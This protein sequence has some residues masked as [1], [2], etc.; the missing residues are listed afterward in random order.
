MGGLLE[1]FDTP[2][3]RTAD[4]GELAGAKDY[5]DDP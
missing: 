3:D 2:A 1:V 5:E 4:L